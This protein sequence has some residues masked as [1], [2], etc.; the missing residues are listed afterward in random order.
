MGEGEGIK[1]SV[2]GG[3]IVIELVVSGEENSV[4]KGVGMT[5]WKGERETRC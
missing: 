1:V 3:C 5:G 4:V 2:Y